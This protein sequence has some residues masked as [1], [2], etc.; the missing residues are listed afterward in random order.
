MMTL[1]KSKTR[2]SGCTKTPTTT[3]TNKFHFVQPS[4][5]LQTLCETQWQGIRLPLML[6]AFLLTPGYFAFDITYSERWQRAR[7]G[8]GILLNPMEFTYYTNQGWDLPFY[9]EMTEDDLKEWLWLQ[10]HHDTSPQAVSQVAKAIQDGWK[11]TDRYFKGCPGPLFGLAESPYFYFNMVTQTIY[12]GI[13]MTQVITEIGVS[14]P[15][16]S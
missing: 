3:S 15:D 8:I 5:Q 10:G 16:A 4:R 9:N 2:G 11:E 13:E 1:R 7:K 14:C 6:R 12:T